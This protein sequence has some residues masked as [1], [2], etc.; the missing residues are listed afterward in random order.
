M[1]LHEILLWFILSNFLGHTSASCERHRYY[2][3][4][5]S[6]MKYDFEDKHM[7]VRELPL[8]LLWFPSLTG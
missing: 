8:P 2:G 7:Y 5:G 3:L 1:R 6:G 4:E